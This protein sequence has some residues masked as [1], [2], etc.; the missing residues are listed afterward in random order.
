MGGKG[1][2]I[3]SKSMT[4]VPEDLAGAIVFLAPDESEFITGQTL[5]VDGG[6]SFHCWKGL[7]GIARGISFFPKGPK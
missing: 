3:L 7:L 5:L 1:P 4:K 6:A 2:P